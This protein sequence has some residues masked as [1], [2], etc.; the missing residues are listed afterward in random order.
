MSIATL[1]IAAVRARFS[2]LDR[3]LRERTIAWLGDHCDT[4]GLPLVMVSHDERDL[5]GLGAEIVAH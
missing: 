1:D 3:P 5:A 4:R 2:A